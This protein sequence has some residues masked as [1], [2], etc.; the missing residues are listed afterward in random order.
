MTQAPTP[1]PLDSESVKLLVKGD[2]LRVV[3]DEVM[4]I[5]SVVT[6]AELD[7]DDTELRFAEG[8]GLSW[9]ID[10]FAFIGR[11]DAD[12]WMPWSGGKNPVPGQR[13]EVRL[14]DGAE[15]DPEP[16]NMVFW[17]HQNRS[18]DVIAF[19]L[20]PT[21][22]VENP[23]EPC[24]PENAIDWPAAPVEASGSDDPLRE[25]VRAMQ[26]MATAYLVPEDYTDRNGDVTFHGTDT[27]SREYKYDQA[28]RRAKAFANDM[29]Y[30]LDGPEERA[31]MSALRPQPSGETREAVARL[32]WTYACSSNELDPQYDNGWSRALDLYANEPRYTDSAKAFVDRTW[33]FADAILALLSA[34]PLA[35]GG[36]QGEERLPTVDDGRGGRR[37][38]NPQDDR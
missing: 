33:A 19:R 18:F 27:N 20:A 38:I 16:S 31:A 6:F 37:P 13:V 10:R 22:P 8:D 28:G 21:A 35:L 23:D 4:P 12:G 1:G 5:G 15:T 30:M 2:L 7:F 3:S 11:P 17:R 25:H 36:Q 26:R 32:A 24:A 29:I 34:R 9:M 14:R